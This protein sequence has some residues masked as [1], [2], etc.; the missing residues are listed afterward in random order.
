MIATEHIHPMMVH[1]P[2]VFL[3]SLFLIDLIATA[4]GKSL[5]GRTALGNLSAGLAVVTALSAI[6]TVYFGGVALHIAEQGGFENEIAEIHEH[7]GEF[8]T[9]ALVIWAVIRA[10]LWWR[11]TRLAGGTAWVVPAV[12]LVGAVVIV[13]VAYYGGQLVYDLGVNV[14]GAA[15]GAIV[16]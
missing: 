7:L 2:I 3:L 6:A 11:D 4:R 1:F 13:F 9:L 12:E 14:G 10:V 5:T 16:D 15:S 8:T